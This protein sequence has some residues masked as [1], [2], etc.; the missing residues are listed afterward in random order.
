MA[1]TQAAGGQQIPKH[2][3]GSSSITGK[4]QL[5]EGQAWREMCERLNPA[6]GCAGLQ[7]LFPRLVKPWSTFPCPGRMPLVT[8]AAV[9][10]PTVAG[11]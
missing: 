7:A 9:S 6:T 10:M 3:C 5:P 8:R 4:P 2:G 1:A 11:F